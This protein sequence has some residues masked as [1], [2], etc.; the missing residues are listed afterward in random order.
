[1]SVK[2]TPRKVRTFRLHKQ[3]AVGHR[4]NHRV[5]VGQQGIFAADY[6]QLN[7]RLIETGRRVLARQYRRGKI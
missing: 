3:P 2:Y 5:R 1:M 4:L 6:G 7:W